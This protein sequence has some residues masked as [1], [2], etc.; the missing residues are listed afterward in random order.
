MSRRPLGA[1][2]GEQERIRAEFIVNAA[3]ELRTP[4]TNLQGYLEALRDGV[5][6]PT[7]EQFRSL[8]EEVERLVR[9]ARSLEALADGPPSADAAEAATVDAAQA[10]RSAVELVRPA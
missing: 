3:H 5:I 2:L 9:L 1:R 7:S 10:V 4:L 6:E 8:H